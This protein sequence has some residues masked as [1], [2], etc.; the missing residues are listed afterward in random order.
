MVPGL[1]SGAATAPR[2]RGPAA[3]QLPAASAYEVKL[4]CG[5]PCAAGWRAGTSPS[6]TAG[7]APARNCS[8]LRTR[9]Q[10]HAGPYPSATAAGAA[11]VDVLLESRPLTAQELADAAAWDKEGWAGGRRDELH[12]L[13]KHTPV[14]DNFQG[15]WLRIWANRRET[16]AKGGFMTQGDRATI[17][18]WK[19]G[20]RA[21]GRYC[22]GRDLLLPCLMR[23]GD[24]WG[25]R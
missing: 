8:P 22:W 2:R 21:G 1:S 20:G 14:A 24:V 4:S 10:P 23:G 3:E 25:R 15:W 7:I 16:H 5:R 11:P 12:T 6:L 9:T 19:A 13:M 18:A 17:E